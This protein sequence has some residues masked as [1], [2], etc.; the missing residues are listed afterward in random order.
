MGC[1][2]PAVVCWACP[3]SAQVRLRGVQLSLE[4]ARGAQ[5]QLWGAWLS[6]AGARGALGQGRGIQA[7]PRPGAPSRGAEHGRC[8]PGQMERMIVSMQDPDMGIKMRNQRLLIT[9]IPHAMTGGSQQWGTREEHGVG[10]ACGW[11]R[12]APALQPAP[13]AAH[14]P[15]RRAAA[16]I[17]YLWAERGGQTAQHVLGRAPITPCDPLGARRATPGWPR[18][19]GP[20]L[21]PTD[22]ALVPRERHRGVAHPEVRHLRGG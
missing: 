22:A 20:R 2:D 10:E 17:N 14:L 5:I 21:H 3:W 6:L 16:G 19:G 9:V 12:M 15:V 4:G 13:R 18:S 8:L 11:S 7:M 1:P